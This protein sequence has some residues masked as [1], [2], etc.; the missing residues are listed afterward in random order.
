[1]VVEA[2]VQKAIFHWYSGPLNVLDRIV[3]HGYFISATPALAYSKL[4]RECVERIPLKNLL[5]ETDCPV[6]Y[7]ET[8]S[9][10]EHVLQTLELVSEIKGQSKSEI[11][12]ETTR[13][14]EY[15]FGFSLT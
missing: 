4:H 3:E 9:R 11:A 7:Q 14:A 6:T 10:P 13:N 1:M 12:R 15:F 2:G 8:V 5:L